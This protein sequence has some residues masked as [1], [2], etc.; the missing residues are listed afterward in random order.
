MCNDERLKKQDIAAHA[1]SITSG[2][3]PM[4]KLRPGARAAK[5]V[6][7]YA[8]QIDFSDGHTTG[9]YSYDYL[10]SICPCAECAKLFRR[11]DATSSVINK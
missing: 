1:P 8:L 9:I 6:G 11:G 5:V 7:N 2:A 4:F 10:R 3:L